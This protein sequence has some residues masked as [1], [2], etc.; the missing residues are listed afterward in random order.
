MTTETFSVIIPAGG[1]GKRL[2]NY[3]LEG[4]NKQFVKLGNKTVIEIVINKF[5]DFIPIKEFIVALP[6]LN[7]ENN[8]NFLLD[9]FPTIK[10]IKGGKERQDSI[11]NAINTLKAKSGK[12]II[13]DAVRPFFKKEELERTIRKVNHYPGAVLAVL[14][15]DTI[16]KGDGMI[17]KGVIDRHNIWLIQT[18]Q[19]FE[20]NILKICYDKAKTQGFYGT[21]DAML[22]EHYG[23]NIYLVE[24][25]YHNFKIT[26]P[27]D[28]EIAKLLT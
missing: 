16:R 28:L 19:V 13:H 23:Y 12:V 5:F 26:H 3:L 6:A 24:G 20:L 21:D 7:F 14:A 1:V 27:Y 25:G 11:F 15:K 4:V 8:K 9:H 22:L 2:Q 17:S 18:P 10:V